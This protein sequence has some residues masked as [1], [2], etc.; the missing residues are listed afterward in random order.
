M[1]HMYAYEASADMSK[2]NRQFRLII[3][4]E[5]R[6]ALL[7]DV[8]KNDPY[9]Q[10][11]NTKENKPEAVREEFAKLSKNLSGIEFYPSPSDGSS[12]ICEYTSEKFSGTLTW[13]ASSREQHVAYASHVKLYRPIPGSQ[14]IRGFT[15]GRT[16]QHTEKEIPLPSDCQPPIPSSWPVPDAYDETLVHEWEG[17]AAPLDIG[18]KYQIEVYVRFGISY[19]KKLDRY[20]VFYSIDPAQ[21]RLG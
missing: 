13:L 3:Q 4:E 11:Y 5:I 8:V 14:P 15:I 10:Q 2:L 7:E 17:M 1:R 21:P 9:S 20:V 18:Q 6:K 16:F 12:P 19:N